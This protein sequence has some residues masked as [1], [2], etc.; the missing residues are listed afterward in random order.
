ML[1]IADSGLYVAKQSGRDQVTIGELTG[2]AP[3]ALPAREEPNGAP[4]HSARRRGSRPM[5]HEASDEEDPR[6]T[7]LEIR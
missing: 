3:G 7:G 1:H 2:E 6:P 4:P 5:L